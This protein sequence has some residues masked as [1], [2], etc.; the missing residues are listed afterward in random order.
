MVQFVANET[1]IGGFVAGDFTWVTCSSGTTISF[2][3]MGH[4]VWL[5]PTRISAGTVF[6]NE[7]DESFNSFGGSLLHISN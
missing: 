1:R 4:Q 3:Q 5:Q 2:L 7:D 6:V